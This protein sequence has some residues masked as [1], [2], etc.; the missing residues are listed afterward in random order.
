MAS[1]YQRG[2]TK[3]R[4]TAA[5]TAP[6]ANLDGADNP[7]PRDLRQPLHHIGFE[8]A[9]LCRPAGFVH[10]HDETAVVDQDRPGVGGHVGTDHV[11]PSAEHTGRGPGAGAAQGPHDDVETLGEW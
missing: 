5:S 6:D 8:V 3:W 4:T 10:L 7:D 11:L 2:L 1:V 9:Q